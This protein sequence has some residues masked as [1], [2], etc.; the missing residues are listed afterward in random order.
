LINFLSLLG[1]IFS[2]W[3]KEIREE[4]FEEPTLVV[5]EMIQGNYMHYLSTLEKEKTS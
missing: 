4:K 1:T 5:E 3:N 2:V